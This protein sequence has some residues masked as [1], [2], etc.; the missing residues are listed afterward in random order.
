LNSTGFAG[1]KT[2]GVSR[3]ETGAPTKGECRDG[4]RY[5]TEDCWAGRLD[6]QTPVPHKP[7][8]S[9]LNM[10]YFTQNVKPPVETFSFQFK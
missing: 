10:A 2:L 6:R 5:G 1:M 3:R 7:M 8:K 4:C 9:L